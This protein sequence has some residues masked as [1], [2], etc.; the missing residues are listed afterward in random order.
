M[1]S[2][3][4]RLRDLVANIFWTKH[5]I[6]NRARALE[7][8]MGSLHRLKILWTLV[9]K[10]LKIEPEC[11]PTLRIVFRPQSI[12]HALSGIKVASHGD[13]KW[14][15]NR[16]VCSQDSKPQKVFNLAVTSCRAALSGNASLIVTFSSLYCFCALRILTR[17][18]ICVALAAFEDRVTPLNQRSGVMSVTATRPW[19][20]FSTRPECTIGA[21]HAYLMKFCW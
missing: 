1:C 6:D 13:S 21:L 10:R 7:N 15:D 12:T 9:F 2:D 17:A 4:R 14:N 11:L 16:F 18:K 8:T 20:K 19:T 5:D 3:F